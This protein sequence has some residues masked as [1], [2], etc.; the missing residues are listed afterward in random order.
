VKTKGIHHVTAITGDIQRNLEF[1]VGFLGLR[2]AKRTVIQ[3]E[4]TTYHLFYGDGTGS[5]GTG[6]TFFDWPHVG[7]DRIGARN[8]VR[9]FYAVADDAAL[10]WWRERF[11][12]GDVAYSA[13]QDFAGRK[14][15]HF[16]DAEGQRLGLV[17]AGPFAHYQH[18]E[19]NV[20]T[21][22]H[23]L[24]ALHSVTLGVKELAP[25][26]DYLCDTFGYE[27][28]QE[29]H[30][31]EENEGEAIALIVDGNAEDGGN[32]GGS[33]GR[34]LV[35]VQRTE[36]QPGLRGI[37][38]VHHVALTI[39]AEDSI[40]AWHQRVAATG[41]KVSEIVR[42]YYFDSLYV[43]IPGGI[44][45]ELATESGPGLAADEPLESLGETLTLPPFLEDQRAE[46]EAKLKP[47]ILPEPRKL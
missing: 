3:E 27:A 20:A 44:L 21:P 18:W 6:L 22:A 11:D 37:G 1:Y 2:L 35:V 33:V 42:R 19:A 43:R 29:F 47:I 7:H 34:E 13:Q 36:A 28:A 40:E 17:V 5:V 32:P 16:A 25:T 12:K 15:L 10:M 31:Q 39:A 45:F 26:V 9:T 41:L 4:P 8:V 30:S 14:T 46:I 23:A 24:Q 38:S